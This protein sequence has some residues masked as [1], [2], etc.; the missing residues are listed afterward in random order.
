ML[1]PRTNIA[2]HTRVFGI[3]IALAVAA[4]LVVELLG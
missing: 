4:T 2:K 3:F 1:D